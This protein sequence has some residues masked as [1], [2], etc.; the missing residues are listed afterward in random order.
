MYT[1]CTVAHAIKKIST[2]G[3]VLGVTSVDDE[4]FVLLWRGDNTCS[5]FSQQ[6]YPVTV[7]SVNDFQL[8]RSLN[9]PG[10][11]PDIFS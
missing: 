3:N 1:V 8:L 7:Y 11:K 9:V 2:Q 5:A 6:K 10:Y 4:L